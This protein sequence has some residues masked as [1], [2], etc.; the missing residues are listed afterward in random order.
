MSER[1]WNVALPVAGSVV[2]AVY[3]ILRAAWLVAC[4]IVMTAGT[5]DVVQSP[6][7]ER[8]AILMM[9]GA[10]LLIGRRMR[11]FDD[12]VDEI[13]MSSAATMCYLDIEFRNRR[14]DLPVG[15]VHIFKDDL[16]QGLFGEKLLTG[17]YAARDRRKVTLADDL[18]SA[19]LVYSHEGR[20]ER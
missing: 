5:I 1:F 2:V 18:K 11:K 12:K 4:F 13:R 16:R 14:T 19:G 6:S 7:W 9:F 3:W 17:C 15:A 20:I 10:V 8:P